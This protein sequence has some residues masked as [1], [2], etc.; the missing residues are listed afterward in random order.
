M[1]KVL[2]TKQCKQVQAPITNLNIKSM[3]LYAIS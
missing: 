3:G 2:T 1:S